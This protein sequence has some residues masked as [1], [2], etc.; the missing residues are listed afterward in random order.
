MVRS[1]AARSLPLEGRVAGPTGRSGGVPS[2]GRTSSSCRALP[3][4]PH[5]TRYA[6]HPPLKGEGPR[7]TVEAQ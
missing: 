1:C 4:R 3:R 6:G 2:T 5:P 7:A